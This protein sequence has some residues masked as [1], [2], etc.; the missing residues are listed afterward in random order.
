MNL[1]VGV[2][3]PEAVRGAGDRIVD[4]T[5]YQSIPSQIVSYWWKRARIC[6][7]SESNQRDTC[8]ESSAPLLSN[9]SGSLVIN[10]G[11]SVNRIS[12]SQ[13]A[14]RPSTGDVTLE[15][16][17]KPVP[18]RTWSGTAAIFA[19]R[20]AASDIDR[21]SWNERP[22]SM[23]GYMD[24]LAVTAGEDDENSVLDDEEEVHVDLSLNPQLNLALR[25]EVLTYV[26]NG[27]IR[28]LEHAQFMKDLENPQADDSSVFWGSPAGKKR[29]TPI[30][31]P[32]L[33]TPPG[34][35]FRMDAKHSFRD[36]YPLQFQKLRSLSGITEE[37]YAKQISMPAQE[38]LSEGASGA[39]MFFC[40]S[41]EFMVKTIS[42]SERD[43][44]ASI[45]PKYVD[46]FQRHPK[47]LLVRFLGMHE[48]RM[49]SQTFYFVVMKNIFP[50]TAS[51]NMKF[52]IKGSWINRSG[53]SSMPPGTK[54]FCKHCGELFR[55]GATS[56]CPQ[57]VGDHEPNLVLKDNDLTSKI[58]M[59]PEQA[60]DIIDTLHRDSD[61]LCQMGITDYSLLVGVRN[62]SYEVEPEVVIAKR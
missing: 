35:E 58:R 50:K 13:S 7:A 24:T 4:W 34:E 1:P 39:F 36:W 49:Y 47:S 38:Q 54:T 33:Q 17:Q 22:S 2:A 45:L 21:Q 29:S 23:M 15:S 6:F 60:F 30:P 27:I 37:W 57:R 14:N 41:G 62:I 20:D 56:T 32:S 26:T 59:R 44:L 19:P 9:D 3:S 46:H 53:S 28:S 51:I 10:K 52:D 8:I 40:G 48:L 16:G 11:I 42:S 25:K 55:V 5:R 31:A 12:E 43:V 18:F 61:A